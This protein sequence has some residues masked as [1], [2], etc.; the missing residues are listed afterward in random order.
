MKENQI[1][2]L[3]CGLCECFG[4][5][6]SDAMLNGY[7]LGLSDL[8]IEQIRHAC[9]QALRHCRFMPS[10]A[11]LRELSGQLTPQARA[12]IAWDAL[13]KAISDHGYYRSVAFDDSLIHA[14]VNNLGGWLRISVLSGDELDKWLRKDFERTYVAYCQQ[15]TLPA[16]A[17]DPLIGALEMENRLRGF[18]LDGQYQG[19]NLGF[20][21]VQITS[22]LPACK[23]QT[24]PAPRS[25]QP[26]VNVELKTP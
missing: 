17:A 14:T 12:V 15:D 1:D 6:P 8:S 22:G 11:E 20:T 23:A 5:K 9:T 19:C 3:I 26:V 18:D 24:L 21:P 2:T 10:V 16:T 7:Q 25:G 4:R 13:R